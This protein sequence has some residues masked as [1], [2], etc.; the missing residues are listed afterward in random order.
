MTQ[1]D[2][3]YGYGDGVLSMSMLT[4]STK[5]GY[6][7]RM[8]Y[9]EKK[10]SSKTFSY[11]IAGNL[12][13]YSIDDVLSGDVPNDYKSLHTALTERLHHH[14]REKFDQELLSEVLYAVDAVNALKLK[15]IGEYGKHTKA[16][17]RTNVWKN[18]YQQK[19]D[20]IR[21]KLEKEQE[22]FEHFYIFKK[23]ID[24]IFDQAS[25]CIKNFA[26][27]HSIYM[28]ENPAH[29]VI[30]EYR[31]PEGVT[32]YDEPFSGS[33]DRLV[34]DEDGNYHVADYK[35]GFGQ[36]S[37]NSVANSDQ[38]NWYAYA[39]N[40]VFGVEPKSIAVWDLNKGEITQ[41]QLTKRDTE[42]FLRRTFE[43]IK[44]HRFRQQA[45]DN[46]IDVIPKDMGFNSPCNYCEFLNDPDPQVRCPYR[47]NYEEVA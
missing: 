14:F 26:K 21:K 40:K 46:T 44:E 7:Y 32:L 9:V 16:I 8:K 2:R 29:Q 41:H 10:S 45:V 17:E 36:W 11:F 4:T 20:A 19:A 33:I 24:V 6:Q 5:C 27:L 30:S 3:T 1:R 37:V 42:T 18:N 23:P 34:I 13:H 38:F 31:I 22:R 28:H 35:T 12:V 15:A 39:I 43:Y 25:R 47:T